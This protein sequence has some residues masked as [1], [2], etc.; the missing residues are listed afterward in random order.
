M[1]RGGA[2][3]ARAWSQ[4]LAAGGFAITSGLALGV[5]GAAHRGALQAK[6]KNYRRN[7]KPALTVFIPVP[8]FN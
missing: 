1:T 5:D 7:G 8:T 4:Y 6:G 2:D 3:N